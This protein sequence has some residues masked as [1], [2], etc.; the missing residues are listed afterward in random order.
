MSTCTK[1]L[2]AP[3]T[4]LN[5]NAFHVKKNAYFNVCSLC[6]LLTNWNQFQQSTTAENDVRFFL[7]MV[8]FRENWYEEVLRQ[9]R[10][11]LAKCYV[12]AFENR[13]A[14]NLGF[15]NVVFDTVPL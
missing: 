1:F 5:I 9:L 3:W 14:G 8:W 12:V 7:Q 10:Q 4:N 2:P 15:N 11:G 6:G 13:G